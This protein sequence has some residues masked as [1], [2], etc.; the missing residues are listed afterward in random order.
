MLGGFVRISQM[1]L[2]DLV[3]ALPYPASYPL[4]RFLA[5]TTSDQMDRWGRE[6]LEG[7]LGLAA[8]IV[9]AEHCTFKEDQKER[10]TQLHLQRNGPDTIVARHA[11]SPSTPRAFRR[12]PPGSGG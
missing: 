8:Y 7:M 10:T 1:E 3:D 2:S 9:F 11:L 6:A 12:D 4:A 5:E